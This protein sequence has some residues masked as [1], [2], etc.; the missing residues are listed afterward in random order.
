MPRCDG[1]RRCWPSIPDWAAAL[2]ALQRFIGARLGDPEAIVLLDETTELEKGTAT[3]RVGP[4]AWGIT[5]QVEDCQAVVFAEY[6][7]SRAYALVDFRLY[8][9][10]AWCT[11]RA[12]R[13]RAH[14]PGD[15]L[16]ATSCNGL[17]SDSHTPWLM[18]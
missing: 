3:A 4:P 11:D 9:Q 15:V 8:L 14:V 13:E 5:G 1:C 18:C 17:W 16:F 7:T 6:V 10:K 12:R 2:A